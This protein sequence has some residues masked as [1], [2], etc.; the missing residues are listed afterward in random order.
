M[1]RM[2]LS[3]I[4]FLVLSSPSY[5]NDRATMPEIDGRTLSGKK[6][7]LREMKGNVVVISFWA[8]WCV[9]CKRELRDLN[10]QLKYKKSKGLR[11]LAISMDGPETAS[12]IRGVV[13]RHK[14]KMTVIHDKDGSITSVSNPRGTAPFSIYVDRSGRVY[15]SHEGYSQGDHQKMKDTIDLLLREAKIKG[16]TQ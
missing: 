6:V 3:T 7:S 10:K 14:W 13:K 9:P 16:E 15:S 8:T 2:I 12:D 4:C 1:I 5:A 11:V